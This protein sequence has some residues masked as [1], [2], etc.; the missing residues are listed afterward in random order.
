M[1]IPR[2][3]LASPFSCE[4]KTTISTGLMGAYAKRGLKAQPF[5]VGPDFIDPSY[6]AI[7][8]GSPSI[9]L[10]TWLTSRHAILEIFE[11]S[12]KGSDIAIIEGV[13]GL[14]DGVDGSE[15]ASTSQVAKI[16]SAPVILIVD[17]SYTSRSAAAL[18]SG[19]KSF[20]RDV[21]IKGVILNG[22]I[23]KSH[24]MWV[25]EAI[26]SK[27]NIP[28][29]GSLPY[30]RQIA[31]PERHLGLIPTRER[32]RS[33]RLV[34]KLIERVEDNID[35][36]KMLEIA[37]SAENI[38][39]TKNQIFPSKPSEKKVKIAVAFD[40]AFN[41]YYQDNLDLLDVYGAEIKFFSPIHDKELPKD[42]CGLYFGGGFPEVLA[43]KLSKNRAMKNEVKMAIEDEM[44]V[45][46]ECG[47]L[48]YLTN[49]I[50]DFS[51]RSFPMVGV[52]PARSVMSKKLEALDYTL[53]EVILD[54]CLTKRGSLIKGHEFHF[55][56]IEHVA[57]DA[58][59]AYKMKRGKGITGERDGLLEHKVLAS[60]MHL[61]FAQN[62]KLAKRFI[63]ACIGYSSS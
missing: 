18:I 28:V 55:S 7:A 10:D 12:A 41:F 26:K 56:F 16:L 47:G 27:V 21:K 62:A 4:G 40:E 49:S 25:A 19:Y 35:L 17:V 24:A 63:E 34:K 43:R 61:H 31:M 6:H 9:N 11:R 46:A 58:R 30:E 39:I 48:M 54:N 59:F 45:H 2:L 50:R 52:F 60:Y 42:V 38:P 14:F 3:I 20:D 37:E 8:A 32:E 22:V 33:S 53:A 36:E 1:K 15:E 13:M 51:G 44:P 57:S 23:N 29:L 5:K